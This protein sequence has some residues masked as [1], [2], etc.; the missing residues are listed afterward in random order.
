MKLKKVI[1]NDQGFRNLRNLTIDIAPR[2][3]VIAG[4]NG[5]GKSTILGLI[6]N[7]TEYKANKTLLIGLTQQSV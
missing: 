5:I 7:G 3:T 1:F 4:H 2:I 6:A